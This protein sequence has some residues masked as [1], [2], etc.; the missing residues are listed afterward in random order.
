MLSN[1]YEATGDALNTVGRKTG[2]VAGAT[3]EG[4]ILTYIS[5]RCQGLVCLHRH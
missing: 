3:W 4:K 2:E 5:N 1:A